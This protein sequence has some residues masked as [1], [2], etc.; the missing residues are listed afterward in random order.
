[1]KQIH[2]IIV[3][4]FLLI[5]SGCNLERES[6]ASTVSSN[7][8]SL[9][10]TDAINIKRVYPA[11]PIVAINGSIKLT[12]I[13]TDSAGEY[14]QSTISNPVTVAWSSSAP[15]VATVNQNGTVIGKSTGTATIT[16]YASYAN[17]TSKTYSVTVNVVALTN[18]VAEIYLSPDRAYV[19]VGAERVFKLTAVDYFGAQTSISPGTVTFE[20]SDTNVAEITPTQLDSNDSKVITV[21]G[22]Q[23]GYAF[24]T[25]IYTVSDDSVGTMVRITGSPLVLQ[26][27]DATESSKPQDDT[28]DAGN[29]LSLAVDDFEGKK[30]VHVA[31]YDKS[32]DDLMYSFFNGSWR[33]ETVVTN[34]GKCARLAISPFEVNKGLPLLLFLE[35][36]RPKLWFMRNNTSDWIDSTTISSIS[37]TDIFGET[38]STL[39]EG[40]KMVDMSAFEGSEANASRL[41]IVYFD[42][43]KQRINLTTSA[44]SSTSWFDWSTKYYFDLDGDVQSVSAAHN[45]ISGDARFAYIIKE[46]EEGAADGGVYYASY[47]TGATSP[48][49]E[50]IPNTDGTEQ[51]VVLKLDSNNVPTVVWHTDS[52]VTIVSRVVQSGHFT[53][54][55]KNISIEPRPST[56]DSVDFSFDAYN[57]PRLVFNAD[58]TIKYSRRISSTSGQ[59]NWIVENPEVSSTSEQGAY[60]AIA[61]DSENRAHLVYTDSESQ[62]FSYWAEPNFF[63]YRVYP[64]IQDIQ[65]DIVEY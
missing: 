61:V 60:S 47:T 39:V 43:T 57:T 25:P 14:L 9:V 56:I 51:D 29:Y 2:F 48:R 20:V 31:H 8:Q 5:F 46:S 41:H 36:N 18:D 3:L 54:M 62:W 7:T 1:M 22:K 37:P 12:A 33:N 35:N 26:V 42:K 44:I 49:S 34:A 59:D 30:I 15:G 45:H 65:A 6:N 40:E 21:T 4:L 55:S 58:N 50:K 19:D 24:I 13:V 53:W 52:E 28:V 11:N 63:D 17:F 10:S 38:N 64:D 16:L 32:S 23:K 27:K